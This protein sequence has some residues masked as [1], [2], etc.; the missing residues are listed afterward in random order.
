MTL[1]R[2]IAAALGVEVRDIRQLPGG[3]LG[4]AARVDLADD[5]ALVAKQGELVAH[6]GAMLRAIA[7]TGAPAPQVLHCAVDLLVM[8]LV[9]ADGRAGWESL[10][11]ALRLLHAPGRQAYGWHADYAFGRVGIANAPCDTWPRFWAERR[12]LPFCEH[13]DAALARRLEGLAER[14]PDLL[15]ATPPPALLHGDLWRGNVLFHAGKLAALIDPACY[16]GDREVDFAMLQVFDDPPPA[17]FAASQL[18]PG[19]RER[20]PAYQL[21]PMLVHLRLFGSGYRGRV[22]SLLSACGA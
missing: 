7:A 22:E 14:L 6:E 13:V 15:P 12:L 17:F 16:I 20:L 4:G 9:E 21:W 3:D 1:A 19:W 18:A 8:E 2:A 11:E 10:A 5:R